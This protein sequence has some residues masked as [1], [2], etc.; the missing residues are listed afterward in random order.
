MAAKISMVSKPFPFV[1]LLTNFRDRSCCRG[2]FGDVVI[3]YYMVDIHVSRLSFA[4]V[5]HVNSQDTAALSFFR[6]VNTDCFPPLE[7]NS[8]VSEFSFYSG[9][10]ELVLPQYVTI[11]YILSPFIY[12]FLSTY[13]ETSSSAGIINR[14]DSSLPLSHSRG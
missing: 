3:Q 13:G 7:V 10:Q 14:V 2:T 11:P 5:I 12:L 9:S 1:V 4:A 8:W 6:G